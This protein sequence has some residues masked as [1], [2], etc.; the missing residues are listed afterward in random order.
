MSTPKPPGF[1]AVTQHSSQGSS[2]T[3]LL[4]I[5]RE[6]YQQA[7]NKTSAGDISDV[8]DLDG[9]VRWADEYLQKHVSF[10]FEQGFVFAALP[11]HPRILVKRATGQMTPMPGHIGVFEPSI[12]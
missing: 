11:G 1:V 4:S 12:N 7:V 10:F 3:S 6:R 2:D 8:P 9:F 5:L